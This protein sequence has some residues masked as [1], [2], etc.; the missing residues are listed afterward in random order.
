MADTFINTAGTIGFTVLNDGMG[1]TQG[2]EIAV[3]HIPGG[4]V[5]YFDYGGQPPIQ[6]DYSL[7]F[8]S[9]QQYF[10]ME[11][12]VGGT[13]TLTSNLDSSITS[14]VLAQLRRKLRLP[15]G[16]TF[17]DATFLKLITPPV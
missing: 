6:L 16:Q 11:G 4:N 3:Q 8:T 2:A 15:D 1:R 7:L 13:A 17:A 5:T 12:Q 9:E 10:N 14:V